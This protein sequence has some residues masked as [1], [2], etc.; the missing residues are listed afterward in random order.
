MEEINDNSFAPKSYRMA[1]FLT[2]MDNLLLQDEEDMRYLRIELD[3]TRASENKMLNQ[4]LKDGNQM[5]ANT[6]VSAF[7]PLLQTLNPPGLVILSQI[8]NMISIDEVK[9]FISKMRQESIK[10]MNEQG[11]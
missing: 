10:I 5:I 11:S 8:E 3:K 7:K 4:M 6:L 9:E 2:Y 1:Q